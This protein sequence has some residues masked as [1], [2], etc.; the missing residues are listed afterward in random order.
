MRTAIFD[1][2]SRESVTTNFSDQLG[3]LYLFFEW[4]AH[5]RL[6]LILFR[7]TNQNISNYL[8]YSQEPPAIDSYT[9]ETIQLSFLSTQPAISI[10]QYVC[11]YTRIGPPN[12][13]TV[14]DQAGTTSIYECILDVKYIA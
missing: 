9:A 11:K 1:R 5:K 2:G 4:K 7:Y 8:H 3:I 6:Q 14:A 13:I 10:S 12:R